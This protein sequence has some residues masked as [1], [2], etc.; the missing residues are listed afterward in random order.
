MKRFH[1][2]AGTG[3]GTLTLASGLGAGF[4]ATAHAASAPAHAQAMSP[5][6][7]PAA[8]LEAALD[9]LLREH[10]D[11]T[12]NVVETAVT[13]GAQSPATAG[14]LSA[15]AQNTDALGGAFGSLY[16]P[17][18][19]REFLA[20]WRPHITDFV[21]YTLALATHKPAA[22]AAAQRRLA[23]Y[24]ESFAGFVSSATKLPKS[25]VAAEL[26]GH[27]ATL[28]AA[29]RAIVAQSPAAGRLINMAAAHMDGTAQVLTEGITATTAVSGSAT[30]PAAAL[31]AALTGLLIQHVADTG[32][33]V[34]TAVAAK[35]NLK[36]PEVAGAVA[37]LGQNTDQLGAAFKS[38]FGPGAQ[39]QFLQ[40]WRGH[41]ANFVTYTLG[42]A[43]HSAS[44]V[45]QAQKGLNSYVGAFSAFVHG[46]TML[47]TPAVAADLRAHIA[48]L[49]KAIDALIAANR[50]AGN[51]LSMAE[52]HMAGTAAVLAQGI[53]AA[54]PA[55]FGK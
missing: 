30:A 47:P 49:E 12:A 17:A 37:A 44:M 10:V 32:F 4:G 27:V 13:T 9:E 39:T 22:A 38:I 26:R 50:S 2:I 36:A 29:I 21:D 41:I 42:T 31:R 33:V 52:S 1:R 51:D 6:A 28:S 20:L 34:Q 46:A 55:Q 43:T 18:A 14:A 48:T 3:L 19:K 5:S 53:V 23:G 54:K 15:L 16:G 11:L 35:G 8:A 25:A 45:S 40:L 24:T 7:T